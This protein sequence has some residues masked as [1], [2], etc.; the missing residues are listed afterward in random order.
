MMAT[1]SAS[2][3]SKW[4][5]SAPFVIPAAFDNVAESGAG[6]ADVVE[7]LHRGVDDLAPSDLG[8]GLPRG[9]SGSRCGR[10]FP[11][12]TAVRRRTNWLR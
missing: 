8:P 12:A 4:W 5:Y 7:Q 9:H 3:E 11:D 10:S 2:L 6:I 1:A